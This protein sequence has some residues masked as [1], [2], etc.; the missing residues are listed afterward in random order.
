MPYVKGYDNGSSIWDGNKFVRKERKP[1]GR[2]SITRIPQRVIEKYNVKVGTI[3]PFTN[4]RI[5]R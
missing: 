1:I 2:V 4:I 3:T 5:T